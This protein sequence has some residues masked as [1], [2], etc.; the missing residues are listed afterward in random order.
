MKRLENKVALITG[1]GSG[2]GEATALKFAAEGAKVVIGNRN[3][4]AGNSVVEKIIG[5]GGEAVFK[6][7]DVLQ[8]DQ[9]KNL[10]NHTV[11]TYGKIDIAF[12]NAGVEGI[13]GPLTSSNEEDFDKVFG[14]NVK[15]LWYSMQLE[16]E[17]MLKQGSG[18]II[19]TSSV[20]GLIGFPGQAIYTASKHAVVGFTKTAAIEFGTAGIRVNAVAPAAIETE[21]LRRITDDE[22]GPAMD[23]LKAY[24][25]IGRIGQPEEVANL[26]SWLASDE[27]SFVTG[28]TYAVDGA[29]TS[30]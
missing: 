18:S 15:G 27:A 30:A 26:V 20:A 9:I 11:S 5:A 6:R 2:I 29:Y 28:Q 23:Q 22:N 19:N 16:I 14:V 8:L 17:Q 12:N 1:G 21:M 4:E 10:V 7:T 13:T 3:E 24:H 25:P